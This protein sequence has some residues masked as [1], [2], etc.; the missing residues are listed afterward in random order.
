[1]PQGKCS[2]SKIECDQITYF[3][4]GNWCQ[5]GNELEVKPG[6]ERRVLPKP[7]ADEGRN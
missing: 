1:M 4:E 2:N 7:R 3:E 6:P 5:V